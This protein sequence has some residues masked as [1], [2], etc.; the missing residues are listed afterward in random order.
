M[1]RKS[2]MSGWTPSQ[3]PSQSQKAR[4]PARNPQQLLNACAPSASTM[5]SPV[6]ST[7]PMS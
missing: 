3:S 5:A 6:P 4:R 2:L 7:N 1:R